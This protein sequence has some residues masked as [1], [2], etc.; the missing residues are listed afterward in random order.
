MAPIEGKSKVIGTYLV[1]SFCFPYW[2]RFRTMLTDRTQSRGRR[3][4]RL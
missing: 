2:I 3:A 1:P 4:K